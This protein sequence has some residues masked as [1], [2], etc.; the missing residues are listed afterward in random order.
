[1]FSRKSSRMLP[2]NVKVSRCTTCSGIKTHSPSGLRNQS[3]IRPNEAEAIL[4]ANEA[5][6]QA[7]SDPE[8]WSEYTSG[9][10]CRCRS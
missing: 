5:Y 7:S 2:P 3:V 6:G 8:L 1:M 9:N 4:N 10:Q